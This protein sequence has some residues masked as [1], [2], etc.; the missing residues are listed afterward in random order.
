LTQSDKVNILVVSEIIRIH[1]HNNK[2]NGDNVFQAELGVEADHHH[3]L[4]G[5]ICNLSSL[6]CC[7]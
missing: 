6:L 3:F 7:Q 5:Q 1:L 4:E 2:Y